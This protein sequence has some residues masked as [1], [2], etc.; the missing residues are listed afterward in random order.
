M[1]EQERDDEEKRKMG[2]GA[3]G[4]LFLSVAR[5]KK[6]NLGDVRAVCPFS[7]ATEPK[8]PADAQED[9]ELEFQNTPSKCPAHSI[10]QGNKEDHK[11]KSGS[12]CPVHALENPS[13]S[14]ETVSKPKKV[15]FTRTQLQPEPTHS[16]CPAHDERQHTNGEYS[17]HSDGVQTEVERNQVLDSK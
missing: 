12:T 3:H 8:I 4:N 9:T 11:E 2:T 6:S 15:S 5:A 16:R 10:A 17:S 14:L 1:G 7:S 13:G